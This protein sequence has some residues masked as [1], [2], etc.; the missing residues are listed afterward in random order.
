MLKSCTHNLIQQIQYLYSP[1]I[2]HNTLCYFYS[3]SN[4]IYLC[5]VFIINERK[6]MKDIK[7]SLKLHHV[8]Y[9]HVFQWSIFLKFFFNELHELIAKL[10]NFMDCAGVQAFPTLLEPIERQCHSPSAEQT[11]LIVACTAK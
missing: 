10:I 7:I 5:N 6:I 11:L 8:F 2:Q 9:M 1:H 4:L 3:I